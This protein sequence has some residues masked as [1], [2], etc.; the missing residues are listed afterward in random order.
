MRNAG[1][2]LARSIHVRI[3]AVSVGAMHIAEIGIF[4][5]SSVG[6]PQTLECEAIWADYVVMDWYVWL[7]S[8]CSWS[9]HT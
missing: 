7:V 8:V 4:R 1:T 2:L 9:T 5:R 3:L 6:E